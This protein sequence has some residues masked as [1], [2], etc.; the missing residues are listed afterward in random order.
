MSVNIPY[1]GGME[2]HNTCMN[3]QLWIDWLYC[4]DIQRVRVGACKP[5]VDGN[6]MLSRSLLVL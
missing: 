5:L 1:M 2:I 3:F 6:T 4:I